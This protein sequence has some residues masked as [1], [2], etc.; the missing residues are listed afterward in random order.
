[1]ATIIGLL[2]QIHNDELVLPAIQRDFVWTEDQTERLLDSVMRGYPIGIVLLWETYNDLQYRQFDRDHRSGSLRRYRDNQD[3]RRLRIVLD[4]QQRLQSLY[5]ALYGSRDGKDLYL[6]VL[7]GAESDDSTDERFFF[8]F[9]TP[10]QANA[11][12]DSASEIA[13]SDADS[14]EELEHLITARRLFEMGVKD[15]RSLVQELSSALRL[16]EEVALR[17]DTNL[18]TFDESF[19]KNTN[20]LASATIDENLPPESKS[21]QSEPDVL[22]VFVRVNTGGTDLSR[23]ELIFSMLKLNWKESAEGL[24]EFVASINEG[25]SFEFDTDFVVRCLFATSELGGKLDINRLRSR[26]NVDSLQQNFVATCNAIRATVDFAID[27]CRCQSSRLLGG[28]PALVPVVYYLFHLPKHEVP[29]DQVDRLRTAVYLLAL[30]R[31]FSRYS[32][33]RVGAFMHQFL[34]PL[35][36]AKDPSFPLED[37]IREVIRWER[38]GSVG[39]L[40]QTNPSLSLHLIQGLSGAKVQY[41]RNA[42]QLDHIFPRSELRAKD[43]DDND[44]NDTANLWILAAGK[45]QNKSAKHPK[46]Y[47]EDVSDKQLADARLERDLLDYRRYSKFLKQRTHALED[48]LADILQLDDSAFAGG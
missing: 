48:R 22:E 29:N 8:Y 15:R 21:R 32:E 28:A 3:K 9:L 41:S 2:N 4:G 10:R 43:W 39:D 5:I 24:P 27:V 42:P 23:S 25:N 1:V 18:A 45:N 37:V 47:F 6:D 35:A 46:R 17:V 26:K 40:L 31:P 16:S 34:L 19:T 36:Q 38:V 14:S 33:S 13:G 7:S 11:R 20:I 44:I 30:A 12:N